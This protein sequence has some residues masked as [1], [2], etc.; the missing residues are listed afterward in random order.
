MQRE[1]KYETVS[2]RGIH[3]KKA[4]MPTSKVSD[5]KWGKM[6]VGKHAK[7]ET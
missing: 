2:C 4:V 7:A 1:P 3:V 5:R 6:R